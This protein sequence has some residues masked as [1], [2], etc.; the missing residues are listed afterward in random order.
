LNILCLDIGN[1]S[2][3]F[4]EVSNDI[5]QLKRLSKS[6]DAI[7]FFKNYNTD[8]IE[9]VVISSV[10]PNLSNQ[11]IENFKLKQIRVFEISYKNCGIHLLV[12][13]PSEVGNDRICNIA[14]ANKLYGGKSIVIDFG[15]ATTYDITNDKGAFIGGAIAPGIDVSADNLISKASLLKETVYQ[16]PSS[17][18][19]DDTTSNIQSGVMFSGLYSVKGMINHIKNEVSFSNPYIILTGGFGKLISEGLDIDHIYNENLTIE[20]MI[21]I[22]TR[23]N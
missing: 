13:N 5:T 18:I 21:D 6:K 12:Q 19:G 17:V 4:S 16:F 3:T 2:I 23:C 8:N 11:I 20:G 10:V 14:A 7:N 1:T 15:T 9:E 22:Y